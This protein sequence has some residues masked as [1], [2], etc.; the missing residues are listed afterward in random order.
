MLPC[1]DG[2]CDVSF[3]AK[4]DGL[5]VSF[6]NLASHKH[7]KRITNYVLFGRKFHFCLI[8]VLILYSSRKINAT[9]KHSK[10][11]EKYEKNFTYLIDSRKRRCYNQ[12]ESEVLFTFCTHT[13]ASH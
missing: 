5:S 4:I 13:I 8:F 11:L 2:V 7:N 1:A 9:K 3:F 10:I 6:L 12:A